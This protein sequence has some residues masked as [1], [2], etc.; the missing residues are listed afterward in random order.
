MMARLQVWPFFQNF[1]RFYTSR[2][3]QIMPEN[4]PALG[5]YLLGENLISDG[6]ANAGEPSFVHTV[7]VGFSAWMQNNDPE[8][9]EYQMDRAYMNIMECLMRDP[10]LYKNPQWEIEGYTALT[11]MHQFG[12]TGRTNET[13]VVELRLELRFV[14]RTHWQPRVEDDFEGINFQTRYPNLAAYPAVQQV[15]ADWDVETTFVPDES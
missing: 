5:V 14:Y 4:L 8:D 12:D 7:T 11:R 1:T 15:A 3:M 2:Q 9:A 6:D 13:P 10:S